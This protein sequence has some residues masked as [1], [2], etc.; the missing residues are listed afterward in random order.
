MRVFTENSSLR[1]IAIA[2]ASAMEREMV[3]VAAT[4]KARAVAT[5]RA[6]AAATR[7]AAARASF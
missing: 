4:R 3:R 7:R 2:R 6:K 1:R 5:R